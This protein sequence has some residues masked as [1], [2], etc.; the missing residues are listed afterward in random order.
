MPIVFALLTAFFFA[1]AALSAQRGL[2]LQ[3]TPWGVWITLITNCLFLWGAHLSLEPDA[4]LWIRANLL[5]V[6]IG[7]FVPGVARML[8]F[9]GIRK[10]GSSITST[11]EGSSPMFSTLL[12]MTFL[13]EHPTSTVL[14]GIALIVGGLMTLSWAGERRSWKRIELLYPLLASFLFAVKDV[15]AR[16]GLV[17]TGFPVLGAAIAA[18]TATIEIFLIVRFVQD[19]PFSA[20][21]RDALFW[22]LISGLFTGASFLCM[23]S[24]LHLERVSIV[25]PIVN[26][27]MVFIVLLAPLINRGIELVSPRKI[28]GAALVV[29]G[30][31]LVSFGRR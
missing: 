27:H 15:L 16:W 25:S 19:A 4:P 23:F 29:L 26:S 17:M 31:F 12:A 13:G 5:F 11:I 28:L 22:F 14:S 18:L 1:M 30:I 21:R 8:V 24:A 9:R 10:I 2:H 3:A 6:L 7:L 20:L